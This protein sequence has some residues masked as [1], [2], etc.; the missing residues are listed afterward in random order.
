MNL[1]RRRGPPRYVRGSRKSADKQR[2]SDTPVFSENESALPIIADGLQKSRLLDANDA[3]DRRFSGSVVR[4]GPKRCQKSG[5]RE[6]MIER[7][8]I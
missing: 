3:D 4:A 8:K 7:W 5:F 2:A 1:I 6:I